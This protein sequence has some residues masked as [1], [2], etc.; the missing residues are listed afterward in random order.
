MSTT[1]QS[2]TVSDLVVVGKPAAKL[3]A[4]LEVI[5]RSL[6]ATFDQF[7]ALPADYS[8]MSCIQSALTTRDYLKACGIKS[9]VVPVRLVML[10]T[11]LG[12]K[13][14]EY[15]IGQV[16]HSPA[17]VD[18]WRGHLVTLCDGFLI[19]AALYRAAR[20]QP[21]KLV[22]MAAVPASRGPSL[23][24]LSAQGPDFR[25]DINWSHTPANTGWMDFDDTRTAILRGLVIKKMLAAK[26]A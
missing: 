2:R 12:Q 25:V 14:I 15:T 13:Q 20:I 4:A 24:Q 11:Q 7:K 1:S 3:S 10:I 22:P 6:H 18:I 9:I 21:R 5:G 26:A 19:D 17:V 23:A 16:E 8:R